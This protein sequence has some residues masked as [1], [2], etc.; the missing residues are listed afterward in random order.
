MPVADRLVT[1]GV[2]L[3]SC[4]IKVRTHRRIAVLYRKGVVPSLVVKTTI[5][6]I[7]QSD[8]PHL[9]WR[10]WCIFLL[11]RCPSKERPIC[12]FGQAFVVFIDRSQF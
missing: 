8:A 5:E 9:A 12:R 7:S 4:K 10:Y 3:E 6:I 2:Q 1:S 11:V